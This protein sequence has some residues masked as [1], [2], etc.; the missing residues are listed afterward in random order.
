MRSTINS[1]V[2]LNIEI[3][4]SPPNDSSTTNNMST[5]SNIVTTNIVASTLPNYGPNLSTVS[6][7]STNT[8]L[9]VTHL[10]HYLVHNPFRMDPKMEIKLFDGSTDVE[11]LDD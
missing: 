11:E 5:P 7:I 6:L 10:N 3:S 8:T 4:L 1:L 9:K 2:L